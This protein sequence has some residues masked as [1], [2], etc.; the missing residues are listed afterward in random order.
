MTT[1][2]RRCTSGSRSPSA[3][4]SSTPVGR[5][6]REGW[7]VSD[8]RKVRIGQVTADS[9][10]ARPAQRLRQDGPGRAR[11][12]AAR[13]RRRA[14]LHRQH[15]RGDRSRR[16]PGH[17]GRGPDR[18]PRVPRRPGQDP[19]PARPRG[20]AGRH[21]EP[22]HSRS[23]PTSASSR[24]SCWS[25]TCT[26][27][28]RP[29]RPA[30]PRRDASSRSTSAAR[31]WSAPPRRTTPA[32]RSSPTSPSTARCSRPR[33]RRLHAGAAPPARGPGLRAHGGLRRGGRLLVRRK[34]RTGR[35]RRETGWPDLVAQ[36]WTRDGAL[37]YGENPHQRAALYSQRRPCAGPGSPARSSCTARRCP[38]TTT[39]TPTPR[40]G[41][42][43]DFAE[44]CV[45]II[46]HANPCGIAVGTNIAAATP[47]RTRATR[48]PP[49]AG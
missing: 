41:R 1:T 17:P 44:P 31:R 5:M 11:Q 30:R 2:R 3:R 12:G 14:G 21:A 16:A 39:W 33:R 22:D 24:S 20:P 15:R 45:A 4:C 49:T 40:A 19:A 13:G 6:A 26:R 47:R 35:G 37:R 10:Q 23:S 34:L 28:S 46:K 18:L 27:S 42:R 29:W 8:D 32:S 25:P 7:S 43:F 48:C 36:V 9:D 38:T